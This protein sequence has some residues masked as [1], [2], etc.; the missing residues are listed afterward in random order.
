MLGIINPERSLHRSRSEIISPV[1]P[2]FVTE[3]PKTRYRRDSLP[4][5]LSM[6][7]AYNVMTV[8]VSSFF[9]TFSVCRYI[10]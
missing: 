10:D 6:T 1:S 9:F 4:G 3:S 8:D 7:E 2:R 5:A